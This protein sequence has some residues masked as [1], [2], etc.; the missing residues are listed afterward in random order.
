MGWRQ[1]SSKNANK[2]SLED[3]PIDNLIEQVFPKLEA[4]YNSADYM[5]ERAILS[6]RN[7]HVDAVNAILIERY[8]GN[9][10]VYYSFDSVDD[11]KRNNYP[12]DLLNS[13]TPNGLPPRELKVKKDCH[14]I[15][16]CNLDPH[17]GLCNGTRLVIR[18]F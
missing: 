16:L 5:R 18:G 8:P 14:V 11:D 10:K 17:N 15:L 12:L 9:E 3:N 13:I 2:I 4:N 1:N 6:T 7:D